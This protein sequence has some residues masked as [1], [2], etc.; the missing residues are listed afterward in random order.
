MN[1]LLD[2]ESCKLFLLVAL[3][4]YLIWCLGGYAKI[5]LHVTAARSTLFEIN[6]DSEFAWQLNCK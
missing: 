6:I 2:R 3:L 4:P 5:Q 1:F